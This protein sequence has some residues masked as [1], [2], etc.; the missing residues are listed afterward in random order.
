MLAQN[1]FIYLFSSLLKYGDLSK[2]VSD[3]NHWTQSKE[4]LLR[5]IQNIII[6]KKMAQE[7]NNRYFICPRI[8]VSPWINSKRTQNLQIV[9]FLYKFYYERLIQNFLNFVFISIGFTNKRKQRF[10]SRLSKLND[11]FFHFYSINFFSS[12]WC[13]YW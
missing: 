10:S 8:I 2:T 3:S 6:R 13:W 7:N 11:L 1:G 5:T 9:H 12:C 4:T